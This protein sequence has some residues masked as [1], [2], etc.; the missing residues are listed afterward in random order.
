MAKQIKLTRGLF[1]TVDDHNF[2]WLSQWKWCALK[3]N[4]RIGFYAVRKDY[5]GEEPKLIYMHRVIAKTPAGLICDHIN[6]DTLCNLEENLRNVTSA[7]NGW[8]R[9]GGCATTGEKNIYMTKHGT[10]MVTI[11]KDRSL[12]FNKTFKT[13][14]IA[15]TA[16]NEVLKEHFGEYAFNYLEG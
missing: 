12:I 6:H 1:A 8:N 16:R 14:E 2:E 3:P 5:S 11:H 10:F 4:K 7:Q 9:R 15:V 13:L